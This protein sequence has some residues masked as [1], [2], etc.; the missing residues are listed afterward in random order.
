M[1]TDYS[2][3]L[4]HFAHRA[5]AEVVC[6][7]TTVGACRPLAAEIL[8]PDYDS[9]RGW[10]DDLIAEML[11]QQPTLQ[12]VVDAHNAW[13]DNPTE[14]HEAHHE[15]LALMVSGRGFERWPLHGRVPRGCALVVTL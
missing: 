4:A 5:I 9:H 7:A 8:G 15:R 12:R 14:S 1:P 13:L 11:R 3:T 10:V 2:K 6:N